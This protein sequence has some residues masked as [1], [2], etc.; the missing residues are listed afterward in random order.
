MQHVLEAFLDSVE[1]L[2]NLQVA[3]MQD[4]WLESA[5]RDLKQRDVFC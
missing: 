3:T 2:E 4:N 1:A 5:S